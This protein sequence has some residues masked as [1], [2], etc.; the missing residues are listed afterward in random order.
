MSVSAALFLYLS[1]TL[2][3]F[4]INAEKLLKTNNIPYTVETFSGPK[5]EAYKKEVKAF[6]GQNTVPI[7][8]INKKLIGGYTELEQLRKKGE[9]DQYM[10]K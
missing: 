6:S 10:Q 8:Y 9:L 3:R 2:G 7:I 1:L 5:G 4:C